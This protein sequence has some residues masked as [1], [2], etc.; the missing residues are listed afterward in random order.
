MSGIRLRRDSISDT[1]TWLA[2][3][4]ST[5]MR[6][7]QKKLPRPLRPL[8]KNSCN[9]ISGVVFIETTLLQL[10]SSA[11]KSKLAFFDREVERIR[12]AAAA[13]GSSHGVFE[14][15]SIAGRAQVKDNLPAIDL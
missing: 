15:C 12:F 5:L 11:M 1:T 13:G 10:S 14:R 9:E 3:D 2:H 6:Q 7:R 8:P 4:A